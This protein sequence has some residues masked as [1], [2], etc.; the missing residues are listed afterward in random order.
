M[1]RSTLNTVIKAN[2]TL[3]DV[4]SLYST[5][6]IVQSQCGAVET[7]T[8][9]A[10]EYNGEVRKSVSIYQKAVFDRSSLVTPGE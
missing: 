8:S 2:L 1:T 7:M 10:L 4:I 9:R 6:H 5:L 3:L